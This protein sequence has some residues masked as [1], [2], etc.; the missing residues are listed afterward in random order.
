MKVKRKMIQKIALMG[1]LLAGIQAWAQNPVLIPGTISGTDVELNLQ[2]GTHEFF[3]GVVTNTMG[4]NGD[5]LGPTLLL[6]KGDMVQFT[7]NNTLEDTTTI[8]WHGL[9][10]SASNDGGP[11][12]VIA[13]GQSWNPSFEIR[14]Q[15]GTYWYHPHLHMMTNK[16]VSMG[17][18]GFIWVR[19]TDE[20]ALSLP[21]TYGVDD[22]P[23]VIQTIDFDN[24]GQ[25][26]VPSN[27]DDVV[28]V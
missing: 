3:E 10:V 1:L 18:A 15:A 6:N 2:T 17:I 25:I 7:V 4:A 8:H 11:H 13:P 23:L 20:A 19:D 27:S 26:V 28:M 9:H 21:R 24:D 14:D 16:H 22:F 5:I 12:T